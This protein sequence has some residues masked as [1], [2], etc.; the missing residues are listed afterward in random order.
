[1]NYGGSQG[2]N[3]IK[4]I[5]HRFTMEKAFHREAAHREVERGHEVERWKG[6]KGVSPEWH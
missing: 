6:G 1:M 3:C 2:G 5:V 4:I